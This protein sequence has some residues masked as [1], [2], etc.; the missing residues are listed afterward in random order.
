LR[1]LEIAARMLA[2]QLVVLRAGTAHEVDTAFETL[3][4]RRIQAFVVTADAYLFGLQDQLVTL[5]ARHKI[6]T[7]YPLSD[8]AQSGGLISYGANRSEA[9]R[10]TGF[11]VGRVLEGVQPA[12]F[13][14]L[15]AARFEL[16][17]N[18]NAAKTLGLTVPPSL[19]TLADEV[20]E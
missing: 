5:A 8:Y 3:A 19:L 4:E 9:F 14:V 1:D 15:Q 11:Y 2:L 10:R 16:V 12:D 20:I 7:I 18:L 13:P 17:V 6:P